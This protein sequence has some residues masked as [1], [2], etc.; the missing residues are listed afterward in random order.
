MRGCNYL[1]RL[2]LCLLFTQYFIVSV[3]F[4][5]DINIDYFL[6]R[7]EGNSNQTV[8]AGT[9]NSFV[10]KKP[11]VEITLS[12]G[13]ITVLQFGLETPTAMIFRGKG[14]INYQP[15]NN[16]E[17]HQLY[18]F[19]GKM[20]INDTF[21]RAVFFFNK[22]DTFVPDLSALNS[23]VI[24][25]EEIE[26]F[27]NACDDAFHYLGVYLPNELLDGLV[28]DTAD[29]YCY[30]DL[31]TRKTDH[32]V[33]RE[34]NTYDDQYKI[35]QLKR[36]AG[37]RTADVLAG[38]TPGNLLL[39]ERGGQ[40]IDITHYEIKTRIESDGEMVSKCRLY[41]TPLIS[42]KRFLYLNWFYDIEIKSI[43]DETGYPILPVFKKEGFRFLDVDMD[44]SG[45]GLYLNN[46]TVAGDSNY[47]DFEYE[48]KCLEKFN[49]IFYVK[50]VS[51]WYPATY[52]RD[53]ATYDLIYDTPKKYE[54][55][56]C[57]YR[58]SSNVEN[59]RRI[60]H[61]VLDEP[62]EYVSFNVGS[63][64]SK[65][66]IVEGYPPVEIYMTQELADVSGE[67]QVVFLKD[68]LGNAGADIMNSLAFFTSLFGPCPFD[69][70]KV[71]SIPSY[72]GQ[73]SPG[74]IYLSANTFWDD[75]LDGYDEVFRAHEMAHQW[76]G[77]IVDHESYRDT[78][79]TEGLS[80]YCGL[81]YYQQSG[82]NKKAYDRMLKYY[83]SW[84][85]SGTG[86]GSAGIN[87][88]SVVLGDR[89]ISTDT[90]DYKSQV[91]C[92][93]AYIFH[94][95]RYILHDYKTESDD[96]FIAFLKD[97]IEQF[98]DKPITTERLQGV[99]EKH[100]GGDMN[101]F[102]DQ[103]VYSCFYPKYKF[104]YD[105]KDVKDDKT[106]VTCFIDQKYVPLGF[107]ALVPITII[108]DGGRYVHYKIWVDKPHVEM[109]FPP[110]PY[111]TKDVIFNTY[112]AV[113]C[114]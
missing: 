101:W 73:G 75:D 89:L 102:F 78:W 15:P 55:V 4:S 49:S 9:V 114:E 72:S 7:F 79:I 40:I 34:S 32:L 105:V 80:E 10:I 71:T 74:L 44:E 14:K 36:F 83:R 69:T 109:T 42:G 47:I 59:N 43:T 29:D 3:S 57:G 108:F 27:K 58:K 110:M 62:A 20:E 17:S 46:P 26:I 112:N 68:R 21:K 28:S 99:L 77:H 91:Y 8:M 93:G 84:I 38:Y 50:S 11:Q 106:Q 22:S 66:I 97:L 16:V 107:K 87:A 64:R 54:V 88:G 13:E 63:F 41:Y 39:S 61:F 104:K 94:M 111:K 98:R 35:Y 56:S 82:K 100:C 96:K 19:T 76:W 30:I 37:V 67:G 31:R 65:E 5:A 103:W 90:D 12:D 85:K 51:S 81:W 2:C 53:I 92:K 48:T 113:L 23:R 18:K 70:I 24:N 45:V 6:K 1:I 33:F 52:C 25:L 86:I 95:I 60:D